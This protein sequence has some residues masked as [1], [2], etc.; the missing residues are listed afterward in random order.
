MF[1]QQL[2]VKVRTLSSSPLLNCGSFHIPLRIH[3]I[4]HLTRPVPLQNPHARD[5]SYTLPPPP[6]PPPSSPLSL[7]APS[8]SLRIGYRTLCAPPNLCVTPLQIPLHRQPS[9]H[10]GAVPG[11]QDKH[12]RQRSSP[13]A[14]ALRLPLPHPPPSRRCHWHAHGH[15][16]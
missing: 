6:P 8:R 9:R 16:N 7:P 14:F 5:I 3:L 13:R 10:R 1:E 11:P 2:K 12:V 15:S 4:Q